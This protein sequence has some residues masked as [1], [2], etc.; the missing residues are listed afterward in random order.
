MDSKN[1]VITNL[2][3]DGTSS[4][5]DSADIG[6]E[7]E[8]VNIEITEST[9]ER[10][11]AW[12]SKQ[13]KEM[14]RKEFVC[15]LQTT[16]SAS[17]KE[18]RL[19]FDPNGVVNGKG[20]LV[21]LGSIRVYAYGETENYGKIDMRIGVPARGSAPYLG[22]D[23]SP[24][25]LLGFGE[26]WRQALEVKYVWIRT[27]DNVDGADDVRKVKVLHTMA[28]YVDLAHELVVA[29]TGIKLPTQRAMIQRVNQTFYTVS[30]DMPSNVLSL[31]FFRR[32]GLARQDG[33]EGTRSEYLLEQLGLKYVHPVDDEIENHAVTYHCRAREKRNDN[34]R[35]YASICL[36]IK[37]FQM[38]AKGT[39]L[40]HVREALKKTLRVGID[41]HMNHCISLDMLWPSGKETGSAVSVAQVLAAVA[42]DQWETIEARYEEIASQLKSQGPTRDLISALEHLVDEEGGYGY[43]AL[44]RA[45]REWLLTVSNFR[46]LYGKMFVDD[47]LKEKLALV[48][49]AGK[50]RAC[51]DR[52]SELWFA[53]QE[54]HTDKL[55]DMAAKPVATEAIKVWRRTVGFDPRYFSHSQYVALRRAQNSALSSSAMEKLVHDL[56]GASFDEKM[57]ELR[58]LIE[59]RDVNRR[60]LLASIRK[61]MS[62]IAHRLVIRPDGSIRDR[63]VAAR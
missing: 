38:E 48:E 8:Q 16:E 20:E 23:F 63:A 39:G 42:P 18:L 43:G 52:V 58:R 10:L 56:T 13:R 6:L 51:L 30:D 28:G 34:L 7:N 62:H 40:P 36:Y 24:A 25:Q 11:Q 22:I 35:S 55:R 59:T 1:I 31:S 32:M 37:G 14:K 54:V 2:I 44:Q 46:M 47:K 53:D 5:A 15:A 50:P 12:A 49:V 29:M 9:K 4:T 17:M 3:S 27:S 19:V 26:N 33:I 61:S 60:V 41:F 21:G 45:M 57:P